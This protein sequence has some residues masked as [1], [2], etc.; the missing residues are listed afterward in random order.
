M[1]RVLFFTSLFLLLAG[2][3]L[4]GRID[5][6]P[7]PDVIASS[8]T[9]TNVLTISC[10]AGSAALHIPTALEIPVTTP[11]GDPPVY[12]HRDNIT[13][14][15]GAVENDT[16]PQASFDQN[17]AGVGAGYL[18]IDYD[19]PK[20]KVAGLNCTTN[21][22]SFNEIADND[23][24]DDLELDIDI[25]DSGT[26]DFNDSNKLDGSTANITIHGTGGRVKSSNCI[27]DGGINERSGSAVDGEI[28]GGGEGTADGNC[29]GH[30][31]LKFDFTGSEGDQSETIRWKVT[32]S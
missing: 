22:S 2:Y 9:E 19:I 10:T 4:S 7:L 28:Q 21:T 31:L 18:L 25:E 5:V 27:D 23:T 24:S 11:S 8:D 17:T 29:G 6:Q 26:T 13:I 30:F 16:G 20:F 32:P 3:I 12:P 1:Y 14:A 15:A